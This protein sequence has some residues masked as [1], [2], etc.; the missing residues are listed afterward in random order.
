MTQTNI[1]Y[2]HNNFSNNPSAGSSQFVLRRYG[3]NY[4][5]Q[6]IN[7]QRNGL[8]N[9]RMNFIKSNNWYYKSH[10]AYGRVGQ[11]SQA[12]NLNALRRRV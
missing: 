7:G 2:P 4:N 10:T 6:I 3:R 1:F 12:G 8:P 9:I 5:N 11:S